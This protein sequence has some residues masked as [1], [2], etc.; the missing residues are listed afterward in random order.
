MEAIGSW[1]RGRGLNHGMAAVE[2][3]EGWVDSLQRA[4]GATAGLEGSDGGRELVEERIIGGWKQSQQNVR[5][6]ERRGGI[7]YM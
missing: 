5:P 4:V 7:C 2:G 3:G 1:V 6:K